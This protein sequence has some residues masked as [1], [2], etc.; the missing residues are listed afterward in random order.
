MIVAYAGRRAQSMGGDPEQVAARLRRLLMAL[1]PTA[2]VGAA[3]DGADLIVLEVALASPTAPAV[4]IVLPTS[5]ALFVEDSVERA[6]RDRFDAVMDEVIRR[7]G[8][9][10]TRD[11]RPGDSAYR[12]ANHEFRETAARLAG[13]HQRAVTLAVA[14]EGEGQMV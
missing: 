1:K 4:A 8:T 5:R 14:H 11:E 2:V 3:A 7:G 6:W 12:Q 10:H 9:I 13:D